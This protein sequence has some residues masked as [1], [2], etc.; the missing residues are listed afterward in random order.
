M[1]YESESLLSRG[2]RLQDVREFVELLGY[3]K[4]GITHSKKYGRFEEYYYFDEKEYRSWIGVLLAIQVKNKSLVVSTRTTVARSFYDLDHQ[5]RTIFQLRKRFG[6][7]FRTDE[8]N[9]RYMRPDSAPPTPAASGCHIAFQRFGDNLIQAKIYL[10]ARTFPKQYQ[11][12]A[13]EF[14]AQMGM[15]PKVLSNNMLLPFLVATLE[16]YFKSTFVALLRYS[17]R[18]Q[19]FFKG[20]RLQGDHLV[21]ISDGE[22]VESQVAETLPFQRIS[23]IA[24]HFEALDPKLDLAGFLK[25]PYRRRKQSLHDL[26]E[27]LVIAR[28]SFIHRA[29]LGLSLTDKKMDD[30]VYDLD[31]AITRVYKGITSYYSWHF[32]RGWY[33]GNRRAAKGFLAQKAQ[34]GA[35]GDAPKAARP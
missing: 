35:A 18:K 3:K 15:S 12:K 29:Q 19:A 9:G 26:I 11:G 5:N 10:D 13:G 32:D 16:D 21:A 33:L 25:K 14:L 28:H 2:A 22:S 31:E 4:T 6:G 24:R 34:Q 20:L 1:S 27:T 17:A 23:S 8:G 30:L 7:N